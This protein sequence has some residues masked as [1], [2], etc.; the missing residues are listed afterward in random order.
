MADGGVLKRL[1]A[2]AYFVAA[3]LV[4]LPILD[5]LT[6]VWPPQPG[7]AVWRY[8]SAGLFTGFVLTPLLGVL[9][10]LGVA[11]VA[12]HGR[13][14]T[15]LGITSVV[16]AVLFVLLTGLFVLDGLQV[17]ASVPPQSKVRF[18]LG[19]WRAVVKYLVVAG[20]LTWLGVAA[21]RAGRHARHTRREATPGAPPA[22]LS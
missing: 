22:V 16:V 12:E 8:G 9:V 3:L 7:H 10:A 17:R 11:A 20:A 15:V 4:V 2:P 21:R 19:I 1:A 14:L 6:N 18:E 13:A 5:F